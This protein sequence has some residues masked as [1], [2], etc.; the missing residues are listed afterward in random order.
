MPVLKFTAGL[1]LPELMISLAI[2]SILLLILLASFT[3]G[4]KIIENLLQKKQYFNRQGKL[5]LF[6]QKH[7]NM[8][9]IW[10]V[11]I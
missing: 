2:S 1:S 8:Q 6:F 7:F 11:E 9:A 10:D 5:K 3:L 4:Q